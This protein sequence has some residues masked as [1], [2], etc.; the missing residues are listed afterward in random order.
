MIWNHAMPAHMEVGRNVRRY[1][2]GPFYT[3]AYMRQ[4]ILQIGTCLFARDDL[5]PWMLA[6]L[7]QIRAWLGPALLEAQ[8]R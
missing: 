7:E 2:F 3:A 4:A 5:A 8:K 6:E 1:V